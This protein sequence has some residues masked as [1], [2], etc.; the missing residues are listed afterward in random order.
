MDIEL[1][2]TPVQ[3]TIFINP[4]TLDISGSLHS[5]FPTIGS[6]FKARIGGNTKLKLS[7]KC[8]TSL[9]SIL[10]CTYVMFKLPFNGS[11]YIQSVVDRR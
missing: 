2:V 8:Q 3:S 6:L 4:V 5:T 1:E 9:T 11:I 7:E 10:E